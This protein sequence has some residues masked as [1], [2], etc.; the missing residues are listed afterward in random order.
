MCFLYPGSKPY[1]SYTGGVKYFF[2]ITFSRIKN[3][4]WHIAIMRYYSIGTES[5][6]AYMRDAHISDVSSTCVSHLCCVIFS[7]QTSIC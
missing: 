3:A 5:R 2:V 7:H 4:C 6:R 1:N